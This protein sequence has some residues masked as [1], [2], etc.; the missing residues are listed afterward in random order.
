MKKF[1]IV[2]GL[3]FIFL[4]ATFAD[5]MPYYI[6]NINPEG[7][8]VYQAPNVIKVY[9]S[10][11]ENSEVLLNAVWDYKSF[12]C[13]QS[14]VSN[15][16]IVLIQEKELGFLTVVEDEEDWVNVIYDRS[17][18]KRGWIKKDDVYRF[19]PWRNFYG[20]YG[21]KYGLYLLKD[22]PENINNLYSSTTE[23]SQIVDLMNK[24]EKIKLTAIKGNWALVTILDLDKRPKTGYLQ[25]RNI[26][27]NIYA[28]PAIR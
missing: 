19:L 17:S 11:N 25:W 15:L 2:L 20:L 6:S 5:V 23:T 22:A 9:Q 7:I 27:G 28:F 4:S 21:R 12:K 3:F 10:P 14:S 1:L 13:P 24:P 8:G 26:R 18:G 16:F